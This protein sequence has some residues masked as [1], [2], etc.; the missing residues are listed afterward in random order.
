MRPTLFAALLGFALFGSCATPPAPQPPGQSV[1][2]IAHRGASGDRPEHTLEACRLA[3]AQG[4][5]FIEPDLVMNSDGVLMARH[6]PQLSD[7]TDVAAR[8]EFAGR[9][10]T[11]M[12]PEGETLTDW[13]TFDFTAAE[14]KALR[15]RQ[16]RAG[17]P[18]A[19]D[20]LH[21]IPDFGELIALAKAEGT[22]RNRVAGLYPETKWL[23]EHAA[24]GLDIAAAIS[25]AMT[26]AGR[27]K[28]DSPVFV[29]SSDHLILKTL[30]RRI[31]TRLV[32]PVCPEGWQTGAPATIPLDEIAG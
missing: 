11:L 12:S 21:E 17:R 31:G 8:P 23:L 18:K 3:I 6:D 32:Q 13:W 29:R 28:A 24:A 27:D 4:A 10:R 25:A 19:H 1:P 2:V 20:G 15:A 26:A 16:V 7:S 9:R 22:A 5:D 14:L 30:R